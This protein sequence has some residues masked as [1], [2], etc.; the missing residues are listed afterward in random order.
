MHL[1]PRVPLTIVYRDVQ[2]SP[3]YLS[4]ISPGVLPEIPSVVLH[5][6]QY[7]AGSTR[8]SCR[9]SIWYSHRIYTSDFSRSSIWNSSSYGGILQ[10]FQIVLL[11]ALH[12]LAALP[13]I[14][15]G[16]PRGISPRV[17][18]GIPP[19]VLA[20]VH[21][22]LRD[23]PKKKSPKNFQKQFPNKL[24]KKSPNDFSSQ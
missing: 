23:F 8:N 5:E 21:R 19:K 10:E 2:Y 12:L 11:Q 17:L 4:G 14:N 3:K 9:S 15:P 13:A 1:K 20:I 24:S 22:F 7:K 16:V 6:I 18:S